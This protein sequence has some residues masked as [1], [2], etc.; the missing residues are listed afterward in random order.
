MER[1]MTIS[2]DTLRRELA[3]LAGESLALQ[4]MIVQLARRLCQVSPELGAA[5][6][7]AFDDAA[8]LA[9]RIALSGEGHPAQLPRALKV[10]EDLRRAAADR[11]GPRSG[12]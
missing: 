5:I 8:D 1:L 2:D 3:A 10:I 11:T 9:E 4:V 12:I 7:G 6:D